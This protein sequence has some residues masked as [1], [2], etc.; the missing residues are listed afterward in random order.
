[1]FT[2]CIFQIVS[3]VKKNVLERGIKGVFPLDQHFE[4]IY[5]KQVL[6]KWEWGVDLEQ[7]NII[8]SKLYSVSYKGNISAK[9]NI[10]QTNNCNL[11][12]NTQSYFLNIKL[13]KMFKK[14]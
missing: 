5:R 12:K 11:N 2:D 14:K 1:M 13:N 10:V 7:Q 6:A 3:V 9:D 8:T 4:I